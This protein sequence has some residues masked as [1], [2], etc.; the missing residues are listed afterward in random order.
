MSFYIYAYIS[1][2]SGL[3]YYIGKGK[4]KRAYAPHGKIK[5]P[6]DR[7]R[8]I[9]M[10]DCL[11]EIGAY[12]LERFYIKWYGRRDNKSGILLNRTD[13]GEGLTNASKDTRDKMSTS[14]A[15]KKPWISER[16]KKSPP[17]KNTKTSDKAMKNMSRAKLLNPTKHWLG[18]S[19]DDETK[20][21]IANKL[22]GRVQSD[23][24]RQ[25]N[26]DKIKLLWQDPVWKAK[27]LEKR[28]LKKEIRTSCALH[29]PS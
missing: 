16:N 28:A 9:I 1:Q 6:A 21:K 19:R 23:A 24:E 8:I 17:R 10:E 12:A 18:K 20:A 29:T 2:S 11:T 4:N 25:K 26:S 27:M 14:A 5:V 3:P 13:G 22:V 7:N 15:K